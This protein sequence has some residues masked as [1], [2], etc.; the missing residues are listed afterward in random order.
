MAGMATRPQASGASSSTQANP[1]VVLRHGTLPLPL[2]SLVGRV[3]ELSDVMQMLRRE[4]LRLLT[5]TGPGGVGKSRLSLQAG[6]ALAADFVDGVVFVPLSAVTEDVLVPAAIAQA[7]GM[8]VGDSQTLMTRLSQGLAGQ[9]LL[10]I[11]DNFEQVIGAGLYVATM[12][13]A[14]PELKILVTSR[15]PLRIQGEFE[16]AVQPLGTVAPEFRQSFERIEQSDAVTLFVQRAQAS[17][18]QFALTEANAAVVAD[19]CARLD[20]FPLAIELAAVKSW[21]AGDDPRWPAGSRNPLTLDL[22]LQVDPQQ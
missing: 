20:G 12:L 6:R 9:R 7:I 21:R 18:P 13:A 17:S 11:L 16:Y 10:L 19:I 4:D 2:T 5:L 14:C 8:S 1:G 22:S 15:M 3:R